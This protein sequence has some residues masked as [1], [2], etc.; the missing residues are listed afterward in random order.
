M[1]RAYVT[2]LEHMRHGLIIC[3][4]ILSFFRIGESSD[5]QQRGILVAKVSCSKYPYF[6][7]TLTPQIHRHSSTLMCQ[8][9][10]PNIHPRSKPIHTSLLQKICRN[11][12]N[13]LKRSTYTPQPHNIHSKFMSKHTPRVRT[14]W[15]HMNIHICV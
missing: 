4:T 10:T 9:N 5:H 8:K 14:L 1:T 2:R 12:S 7:N 13:F 6:P 15:K 3:H 11:L